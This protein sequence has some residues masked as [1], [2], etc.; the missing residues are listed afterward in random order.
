MK[1]Q[2]E[3]Q[4]RFIFY[5]QFGSY[6]PGVP[7]ILSMAVYIAFDIWLKFTDKCTHKHL[8]LAKIL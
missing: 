7:L 5:S 3:K 2:K 1:D 4:Y 6:L 8:W